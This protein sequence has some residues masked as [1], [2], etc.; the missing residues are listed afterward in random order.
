[1]DYLFDNPEIAKSAGR[2]WE[3]DERKRKR[4]K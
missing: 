1:M 4:K 2:N 3:H